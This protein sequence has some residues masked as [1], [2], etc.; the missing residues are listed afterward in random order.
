MK[1]LQRLFYKKRKFYGD[2]FD[3]ENYTDD[4]Y[5]RR[6]TS[7]IESKYS[8]IVDQGQLHFDPVTGTVQSH[9]DDIHPNHLL[10]LEIIGQLQLKSVH[11]V[12]CGGGDHVANAVTLYPETKVTGG[13]RGATQLDL[14]LQRHP[15]LKGK[16]GLQDITM[17]FSHQW[18]N[19][20]LV[21]TQAVIMHIH[22]AVSHLVALSNLIRMAQ[23]HVL[24]MENIQ[25]HN[26]VSDIKSLHEGGH[27]EWKTLNIY[28]VT[29]S[30]GANAILLSNQELDYPVLLSDS[31]IRSGAKPSS[32]RL[33]R[34]N[35][36]SA[37][38]IFGFDQ[39]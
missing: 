2:D 20:E 33:K 29:G 35:E 36:D 14:A 38:G 1:L 32:R 23:N 22:T 25:C 18:P 15:E 21:Y 9:G 16:I 3:W 13:D 39:Y 28:Q 19:P 8:A 12:G 7:D 37:R 27:L 11:E 5:H 4:S 24:L 30:T 31:E 17:P 34:A 26:F 10:I 6:I